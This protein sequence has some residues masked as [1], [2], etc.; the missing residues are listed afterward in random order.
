MKRGL[1]IYVMESMAK[2]KK[3]KNE[4]HFT[5]Q[6]NLVFITRLN[7][8][9]LAAPRRKYWGS[10]GQARTGSIVPSTTLKRQIQTGVSGVIDQSASDTFWSSVHSGQCSANHTSR[11]RQTRGQMGTSS[12]EDG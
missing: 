2:R 9:V 8:I 7:T 11:R 5:S 10:C 4:Q 1:C 12:W 6:Y 3:K